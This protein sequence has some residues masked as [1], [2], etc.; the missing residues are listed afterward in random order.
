MDELYE[1]Q[2]PRFKELVKKDNPLRPILT[3]LKELKHPIDEYLTST[4]SDKWIHQLRAIS[5]T[6]NNDFETRCPHCCR[7]YKSAGYLQ[8]EHST[9]IRQPR[10]KAF[11]RPPQVCDFPQTAMP[12]DH[13]TSVCIFGCN[14]TSTEPR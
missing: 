1:Q 10:C 4:H 6:L 7:F 13:E 5:L 8:R 11:D 12:V 2:S 3:Q 9:G 14:I